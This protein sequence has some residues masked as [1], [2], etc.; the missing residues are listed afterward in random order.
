MTA[1]DAESISLRELLMMASPEE[2]E[3]FNEMSPGY[4]ET[5]GAPDLREAI[6][7]RILILP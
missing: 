7:Y 6:A 5:F 1:S 3:Q 2:Q 4:T